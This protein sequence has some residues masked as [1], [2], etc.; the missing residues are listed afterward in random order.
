MAQS[1]GQRGV[2]SSGACVPSA[3]FGLHTQNSRVVR[4]ARHGVPGGHRGSALR[5]SWK[6]LEE[7]VFNRQHPPLR[8]WGHVL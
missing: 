5:P 6:R 2:A 8:A 4:W 1:H 3:F 7:H